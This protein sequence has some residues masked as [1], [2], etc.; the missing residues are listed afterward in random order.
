MFGEVLEPVRGGVQSG[1]NLR[2]LRLDC[3]TVEQAL[4]RLCDGQG[5]TGRDLC[6]RLRLLD[7]ALCLGGE[8]GAITLRVGIALGHGGGDTRLLR[9]MRSTGDAVV[10]AG[11]PVFAQ[12]SFAVR[13]QASGY[14]PTK[15]V[16]CFRRSAGCVTID[17]CLNGW[18]QKCGA[19]VC[20]SKPHALFLRTLRCEI[21]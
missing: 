19:H 5:V 14:L 16:G 18:I 12:A 6:G 20:F 4:L 17:G 1:V 21:V 11:L 9:I 3:E 13:S 2:G 8:E 10:F 15:L 7:R